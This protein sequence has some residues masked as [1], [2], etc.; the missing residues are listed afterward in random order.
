MIQRSTAMTDIRRKN[1]RT[2]ISAVLS[3]LLAD[4]VALYLKTKNFHRRVGRLRRIERDGAADVEPRNL[5][6]E[7]LQDNRQLAQ[8]LRQARSLCNAED[9]LATASLRD[10]SIGE[11]ED[12]A[13]FLC[14]APAR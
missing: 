3:V 12:R 9:D 11:A 2:D 4:K 1:L 10:D 7:L 5:L 8:E 13:W 14:A 6:A